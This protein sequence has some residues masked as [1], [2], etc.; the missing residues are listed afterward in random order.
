MGQIEI[1]NT[2]KNMNKILILEDFE[3]IS[4]LDKGGFS[5]VKKVIFYN[6]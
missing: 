6:P 1:C 2:L 3:I 5:Q 4:L